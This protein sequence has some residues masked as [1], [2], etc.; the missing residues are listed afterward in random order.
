M[1]ERE[2]EWEREQDKDAAER[3]RERDREDM[4]HIRAVAIHR[5]KNTV[6]HVHA[7]APLPPNQHLHTD[8]PTKQAQNQ[9]QFQVMLD[10]QAPAPL[11]TLPTGLGLGL[12]LDTSERAREKAA[13][14]QQEIPK[15]PPAL[16]PDMIHHLGTYRYPKLPF[17]HFFPPTLSPSRRPAPTE[18]RTTI[19]VPALH[20]P[21]SAPTRPR[22]WGGGAASAH[23]QTRR[24]YT[25]DSDPFLCALHS[26][27]VSWSGAR[28][29]RRAGKGCKI[30][31]RVVRCG[32]RGLGDGRGGEAGELE[33]VWR[34]VGGWG[35]KYMGGG[36]ERGEEDDGRSLLS[37]GWGTSHDGSGIEVVSA[38]FVDK[39]E[40][41]PTIP[42]RSQRLHEYTARRAVICSSCPGPRKKR[43]RIDNSAID[44]DAAL[45]NARTIV[46]GNNHAGFK[47]DPESLSTAMFPESSNAQKKRRLNPD[48]DAE[49][50]GGMA[51]DSDAPRTEQSTR[52]IILE[53]ETEQFM[54]SSTMEGKPG[55]GTQERTYTLSSLT[56]TKTGS[57]AY[58]LAA[59]V[60]EMGS[61]ANV[62]QATTDAP[63][64]ASL[65]VPPPS[66]PLPDA[67]APTS[68]KVNPPSEPDATSDKPNL[69]PPQGQPSSST[70]ISHGLGEAQFSFSKE[71]IS[72]VYGEGKAGTAR[73][74]VQM[75]RWAA[76]A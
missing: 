48:S 2:R 11:A 30:V 39:C 76:P 9:F 4:D 36:E 62:P 53:T 14:E 74:D 55:G 8:H 70:V 23:A 44:E 54:L 19:L 73:M 50:D 1:R 28:E 75:W 51:V 42:T 31:L 22:I 40:V 61:S 43:R 72:L 67:A 65:V 64:P 16:S 46:F 57:V 21:T 32:M 3:E 56:D 52:P 29:A 13:R 69:S 38:G 33:V 60:R 59:E 68:P 47:Y 18:T 20:L 6:P 15:E 49:P 63:T 26:G 24:I 17:P 5:L 25:D 35:A 58:A 34:F 41:E 66:D 12:T 37:A 27:Y 10:G 45:S 7:P 71:G